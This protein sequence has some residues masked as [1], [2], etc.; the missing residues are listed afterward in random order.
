MSYAA[1]ALIASCV[2][3]TQITTNWAT[4]MPAL[5]RR[6]RQ[7]NE[8][9]PET[10]PLV[11]FF[12]D[13]TRAGSVAPAVLDALRDFPAVFEV[14][15]ESVSLC[16][17]GSFEERN[18]AVHEVALNLR[19]RGIL[20]K[21]RDE[22]LALTTRFDASPPALLVERRMIP[23]LGGK[24]YG[25]AVNGHCKDEATGEAYLWVATRADDKATW[26]GMLDT[27]AAG[28]LAA[29]S[30]PFDAACREAAEEAGVAPELASSSLKPVG[31]ISYVGVDESPIQPKEDVMFCFDLEVPWDY[32]PVATDGEVAKFERMCVDEVL[33]CVAY[34][35]SPVWPCLAD[36]VEEEDGRARAP[37]YKP[38]I[39][40]VVIDW[41]IRQ[42]HVPPEAPGYLEL[43]GALRQ[44][45]CC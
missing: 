23:L 29:G 9:V 28:A 43:V 42:G 1:I 19:E 7:C 40:L 33:R 44:G 10:P 15:A 14:S 21:W 35:S 36:G 20:T 4:M 39:N 17:P 32:A 38:N 8:P 26:P 30:S 13:G 31:A 41:L 12:V 16:A 5:L 2:S 24:G 34:G 18:A 37:A 3:A 45:T 11:P 22:T 27:I 6:V 25:V